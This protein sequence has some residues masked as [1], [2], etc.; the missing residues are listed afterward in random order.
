MAG[1][2]PVLDVRDAWEA[3]RAQRAGSPAGAQPR[4]RRAEVALSTISEGVLGRPLNKAM[5]CV[6]YLTLSTLPYPC[7]ESLCLLY[8][9]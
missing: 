6:P 2:A 9:Q 4:Q 5:Q 3:L 1:T 8:V 7:S